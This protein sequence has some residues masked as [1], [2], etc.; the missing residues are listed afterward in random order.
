MHLLGMATVREIRLSSVSI[1]IGP[2]NE[3]M[4]IG[5]CLGELWQ[6][7]RITKGWIKFPMTALTEEEHLKKCRA[8]F[9]EGHP[10]LEE[11]QEE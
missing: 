6:Y 8:Y 5:I 7:D 3:E 1:A 2:D 10:P 9:L 11:V 4:I